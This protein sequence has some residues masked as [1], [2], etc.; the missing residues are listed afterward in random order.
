MTTKIIFVSFG[1]VLRFSKAI[2]R[3]RQQAE[4]FQIFDEIHVVDESYL[5]NE[6]W[7][8]HRG[9]VERYYWR[10]FGYWIWKSY[11]TLKY[12]NQLNDGDIL[13]YCDVGC[14]L[15][16]HGLPRFKEYINIV[17]NSESGILSFRITDLLEKAWC[18]MDL[19]TQLDCHEQ[20]NCG[21]L[22]ASAFF[23][24]K[25]K[26]NMELVQLWYDTCCDYHCIDD[27]PSN[28]P[29][30]P[31]FYEHRHDQSVF[32]LLRNKFGTELLDCEETGQPFKNDKPIWISRKDD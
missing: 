15:N 17:K 31:T 25:T 14:I 10:G 16:I 23:I 24:T 7:D 22:V 30:D 20:M 18:K 21:Q 19:I 27:T 13:F 9:F 26:K 2:H 5:S 28:L 1:S 6:F 12:L 4:S 29:N 3:I 11:I 32:S 8:R